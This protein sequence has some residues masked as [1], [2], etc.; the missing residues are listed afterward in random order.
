MY[1]FYFLFCSVAMKQRAGHTNTAWE[2]FR[3]T[4]GKK[5]EVWPLALSP[6]K[7]NSGMDSYGNFPSIFL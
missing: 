4:P 6:T 1:S 5:K 2:H 3:F 7:S